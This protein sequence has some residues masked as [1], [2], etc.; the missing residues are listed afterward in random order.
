[1]REAL[2]HP[3]AFNG[4]LLAGSYLVS[5]CSSAKSLLDSVSIALNEVKEMDLPNKKQDFSRKDFWEKFKKSD[6]QCCKRYEP[7]KNWFDEVNPTFLSNEW[8]PHIEKLIHLICEDLCSKL[9]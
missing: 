2:K 1:L 9:S 3:D 6:S 8:N 5:Y 7:L 4:A